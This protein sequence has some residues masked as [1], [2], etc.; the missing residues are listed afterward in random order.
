M[1]SANWSMHPPVHHSNMFAMQLDTGIG[2]VCKHRHAPN[3]TVCFQ[4][5]S[6][7]HEWSTT[8]HLNHPSMTFPL[9][10][11]TA[12]PTYRWQWGCQDHTCSYSRE[13][14][15][16]AWMP[17]DQLDEEFSMTPLHNLTQAE[18]IN[19]AHNQPLGKLLPTSD[20]TRF[21]WFSPITMIM[22][23]QY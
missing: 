10:G 9:F 12:H 1:S 18:A 21:K 23:S 22:I 20:I 14:E 13:T 4:R 7:A 17:K 19:N 6:A 15:K 16:N 11:H 8:L 5:W 2:S 3:G